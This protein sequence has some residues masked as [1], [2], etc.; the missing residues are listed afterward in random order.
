MFELYCVYPLRIIINEVDA[1][2]GSTD[3]FYRIAQK[4]SRK[5]HSDLDDENL[6]AGSM[7]FLIIGVVFVA[8]LPLIGLVFCCA[9]FCAKRNIKKRQQSKCN[10]GFCFTTLILLI[11]CICILVGCILFA[12]SVHDAKNASDDLDEQ[13]AKIDPG[14]FFF[15]CSLFFSKTYKKTNRALIRFWASAMKYNV[16]SMIDTL[17]KTLSN[18]SRLLHDLLEKVKDVPEAQQEVNSRLETVNNSM[19]VLERCKEDTDDLS[20]KINNTIN[21]LEENLE[22]FEKE[23]TDGLNKSKEET[24]SVAESAQLV[25]TQISAILPKIYESVN[26]TSEKILQLRDNKMFRETG[27]V[28]GVYAVGIIP[29]LV[30][31]VLSLFVLSYSCCQILLCRRIPPKNGCASN[32]CQKV[33]L[34]TLTL[35]CLFGWIVMALASVSVGLNLR[36]Q[37]NVEKIGISNS[38]LRCLLIAPFRLRVSFFPAYTVETMCKSLF[39]DTE[40]TPSDLLLNYLPSFRYEV[41]PPLNSSIPFDL[42]LGSILYDCVNDNYSLFGAM[43]GSMLFNIDELQKLANLTEGEEAE[44]KQFKESAEKLKYDVSANI[45]VTNF[46]R[47]VNSSTNIYENFNT[48]LTECWKALPKNK[49][50]NETEVALKSAKEQIGTATENLRDVLKN[51]YNALSQAKLSGNFTKNAGDVT[52]VYQQI[53]NSQKNRLTE[54]QCQP[55]YVTWKNI[56]NVYCNHI[57]KPMQGVWAAIGFS[58]VFV[59]LLSLSLIC[60]SRYLSKPRRHSRQKRG[61][62]SAD[63]GFN[64]P[65]K[66]NNE[67]TQA[68][69]YNQGGNASVVS[70]QR[71]L[72]NSQYYP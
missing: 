31:V 58:A 35:T 45:N 24:D 57:G 22:N 62:Y 54:M 72:G 13:F 23:M 4:L 46:E 9:Q 56:G 71:Y 5:I 17:N 29:S 12:V 8:A 32:C 19:T 27:I 43:S 14:N 64:A 10:V 11:S 53:R 36:L 6:K 67:R 61:N 70:N 28:D 34:C 60:T 16:S 52:S 15:C 25:A 68:Q 38:G 51:I 44:L 39:Y 66:A 7:V 40:K 18:A 41:K 30:I 37:A 65:L 48:S 69:Y 33:T 26:D 49:T 55:L 20:T 59:L 63:D 21:E 2:Y 3:L 47:D 50:V 1:D 42:K